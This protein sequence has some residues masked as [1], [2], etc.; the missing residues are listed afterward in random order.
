MIIYRAFKRTKRQV[1]THPQ[2]PRTYKDTDGSLV[3]CN[4]CDARDPNLRHPI[5]YVVS[6]DSNLW[7]QSP[8]LAE[9]LQY[10]AVT[11]DIDLKQVCHSLG[12]ITWFIRS[13]GLNA[14]LH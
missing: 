8:S 6:G 14:D 7:W 4:Y 5:E 12:S 13:S 11:I 1:F 10:H 3:E 9:G 2:D